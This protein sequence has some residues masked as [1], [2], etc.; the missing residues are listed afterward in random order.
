MT[1]VDGKDG[2]MKGVDK[3]CSFNTKLRQWGFD[4]CLFIVANEDSVLYYYVGKKLIGIQK[5]RHRE[6]GIFL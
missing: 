5:R 2:V 4:H 6:V 3:S 1:A